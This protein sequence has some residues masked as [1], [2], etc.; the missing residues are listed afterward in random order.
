MNKK[1]SGG[2]IVKC[3]PVGLQIFYNGNKPHGNFKYGGHNNSCK[4]KK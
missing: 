1:G 3:G 2:R 4:I